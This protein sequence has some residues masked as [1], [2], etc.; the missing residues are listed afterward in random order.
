MDTTPSK[1][2]ILNKVQ[3]GRVTKHSPR[4]K[5]GSKNYTEP[6]DEED[7][8]ELSMT[9]VVKS[10]IIDEFQ[11]HS[12][13]Y[14]NGNGHGNGYGHDD[15]DMYDANLEGGAEQYFEAVSLL[16]FFPLSA[17]LIFSRMRSKSSWL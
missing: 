12:N 4:A 7:D 11:V 8:G 15:D 1:K 2:S 16:N 6:E 3:G 14:S 5:A 13:G 9:P 17:L 10:E